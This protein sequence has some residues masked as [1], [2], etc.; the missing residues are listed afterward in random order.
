MCDRNFSADR[1]LPPPVMEQ[2]EKQATILFQG[3]EGVFIL[4][5]CLLL[6]FLLLLLLLTL[7]YFLVFSFGEEL[8]DFTR[9]KVVFYSVKISLFESVLSST[10]SCCATP[11]TETRGLKL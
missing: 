6:S 5:L 1:E 8:Y 3:T 4:F 9:R 2:E 7:V 11:Q 10:Q